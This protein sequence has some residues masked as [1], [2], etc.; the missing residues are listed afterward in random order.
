MIII[1]VCGLACFIGAYA[2]G[3]KRK[4]RLLAV[5]QEGSVREEDKARFAKI[6]GIM[7]IVYGVLL[8]IYAFTFTKIHINIALVIFLAVVIIHVLMPNIMVK[9]QHTR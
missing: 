4:F 8:I 3:K 7:F 2:I 5:D 6:N 9:N 1:L